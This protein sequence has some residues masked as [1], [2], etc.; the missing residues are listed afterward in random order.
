MTQQ[1]HIQYRVNVDTLLN[2]PEL[3]LQRMSFKILEKREQVLQNLI[4]TK[5]RYRNKAKDSIEQGICQSISSTH[6]GIK[7]GHE[8]RKVNINALIF[9]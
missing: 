4:G 1:C 5:V 8:V 2:Q 9:D 6:C 3:V 7:V